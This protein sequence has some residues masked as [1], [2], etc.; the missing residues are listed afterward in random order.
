MVF[1]GMYPLDA[2]GFDALKH[3]MDRFLLKD[4]SVTVENESSPTL[5]RGL[6]CG[7][8]GMLHLEVVQQRLEEE[9]GVEVLLTSPTVPLRAVLT[10]GA[11]RRV[12][13]PEELPSSQDL[14][15]LEEPLVDATILTPTEYLGAII[16]LCESRGGVSLSQNH[17]GAERVMLKYKLPL[18]EIAVEFHDRLKTLTSGYASL[19]YEAAGMQPADMVKLGLKVNGE[20]VGALTRLVPRHKS[21]AIG[22]QMV[23]TLKG[24]LDRGLNDIVLQAVQGHSTVVARETIK[25][26]RKNVLAKCYGGDV[27]RKKKLLEKQKAGKKRRA[28]MAGP[29]SIPHEAF[30][31]VLAN[32][33]K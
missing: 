22:K 27:T 16:S 17:L 15:S 13:S 7:F 9:H 26:V 25:A 11:V 4:G 28:L 14:T 30:V 23:A 21:Q 3:A 18:A 19:D 5:G 32:D 8:L 12:C 33:R 20:S 10:D 1:A 29:V 6:R 24:E 31:K 2:S